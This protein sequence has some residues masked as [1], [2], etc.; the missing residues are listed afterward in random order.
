MSAFRRMPNLRPVA[1]GARVLGEG[2]PF[3]ALILVATQPRCEDLEAAQAALARALSVD[4][5]VGKDVMLLVA[6]GIPGRRLVVAPTGPVLRDQDDVRAFAE[7]AARGARRARDAGARR[8]LLVV[9]GVPQHPL[10]ANAHAV[11]VLGALGALWEPLEA[12]ERLGAAVAEPVVELGC[13]AEALEKS[14]EWLCAVESGRR[15]ARDL[16][17]TEPERMSP[18]AIAELCRAAFARSPVR[19]TVIGQRA[20]LVR[21]YPLLAAVARASF[22]VP[23]HHP[24]VVRMEYRPAGKVRRTLLLAGKGLVYDTGGADVKAG[25]HMA[26]MSRDKGGAAAVAG[27]MEVV[28]QLRPKHL[29]VVAELGCVRNS[30]GPDMYV[31]D[32][33]VTSHAGV[34]VRVGNTDAEGRLVLADLLSHLREDALEA[35]DPHLF[36][37]ATLTGHSGRAVGPYSIAIENGPARNGGVAARLAS[38]GEAFGDPFELSRLRREDFEFVQPRSRA[39]DVLS[40]NNLPSTM[41]NRGHQ[42]PMA[43]LAIAA[44]LSA[45]GQDGKRPLPFTHIDIGG[46]ANEGGDWQHGRPTAAPVLALTAALLDPGH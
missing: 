32:E 6:D 37:I 44:G 21:E 28:R 4:A 45:H 8:P 17:G 39:D 36:S 14:A 31:T 46:S 25:G 41:T 5:R 43:F 30:I 11:A 20:R 26:G 10:Y 13:A 27:F 3:D 33:I 22:A 23:R 1:L 7:A 12:R 9:R 38:F 35:V 40:C 18:A 34:R 42:F 19:V 2:S 24:C 15:L 29:R 16:G